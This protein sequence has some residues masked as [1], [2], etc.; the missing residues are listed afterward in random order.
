MLEVKISLCLSVLKNFLYS[1]TS[2][3]F[4]EEMYGIVRCAAGDW[5]LT[6]R[7]RVIRGLLCLQVLTSELHY[8]HDRRPSS[9]LAEIIVRD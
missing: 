2:S 8:R 4:T 5:L 1:N 3:T 9:K 7:T 6:D